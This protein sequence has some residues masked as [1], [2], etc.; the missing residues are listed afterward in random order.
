MHSRQ[1]QFTHCLAAAESPRSSWLKSRT[2]SQVVA[3]RAQRSFAPEAL[4]FLLCS[5]DLMCQSQSL[6]PTSLC[7]LAGQSLQ[8][9][10]PAAGLWD[11][12]DV[13]FPKSFP[14]CLDLYPGSLWSAFTRFFPQSIGLPLR[15][16]GSAAQPQSVPRLQHGYLFRGCSHFFMF[17]PPGLLAT[18]VVPTDVTLSSRG[19]CGVYFRAPYELLPP[20]TSDMLAVRFRAIDGKGLS[21]F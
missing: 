14:R 9:G 5:Y 3:L 20:H 7:R 12:P 11:L 6:C 13:T 16:S 18:Q 4:H 8:L 1:P 21:P 19:S 10:P 17:R 2:Y 15:G